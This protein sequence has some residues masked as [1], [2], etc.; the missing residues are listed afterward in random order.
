MNRCAR[1]GI[2]DEDVQE[3]TV[4]ARF[5]GNQQLIPL[6]SHAHNTESGCLA[7]MTCDR[8]KVWAEKEQMKEALR[9]SEQRELAACQESD[10]WKALCVEAREYVREY[11]SCAG[12]T[13]SLD[14]AMDLL[15]RMGE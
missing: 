2:E 8:D 9:A 5:H 3:V 15:Q 1:C 6:I 12:D 11:T 7:A 14:E 10:E 4:L 13:D